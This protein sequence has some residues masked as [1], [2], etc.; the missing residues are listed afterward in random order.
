MPVCNPFQAVM[1][2]NVHTRLQTLEPNLNE[3]CSTLW[4]CEIRYLLMEPNRTQTI[5][6]ISSEFNHM[7]RYPVLF[8]SIWLQ[9]HQDEMNHGK[10]HQT[11]EISNEHKYA[12]EY[13][14]LPTNIS[15]IRIIFNT[16]Q[17][18]EKF[19]G[20]KGTEHLTVVDTFCPIVKRLLE[21]SEPALK[22]FTLSCD[23]VLNVPNNLTVTLVVSVGKS[24]DQF[25]LTL[26]KKYLECLLNYM[27]KKSDK[28]E[29][30]D[31]IFA[32]NLRNLK[33]VDSVERDRFDLESE[34][35]DISIPAPQKTQNID[36]CMKM[37][38]NLMKRYPGFLDT[39]ARCEMDLKKTHVVLSLVDLLKKGYYSDYQTA[40]DR[41]K[42]CIVEETIPKITKA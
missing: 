7:E 8:K 30:Y 36:L 34:Q 12:D 38:E 28:S 1:F 31:S 22:S 21:K 14:T 29:D 3:N 16:E 20:T 41:I 42:F 26:S 23:A 35:Y 32:E 2:S 10:A 19:H 39:V 17:L 13:E 40:Y 25:P 11:N 33:S 4:A 5:P 9:N 24:L 18:G 27:K 15:R 6:G 37:Y